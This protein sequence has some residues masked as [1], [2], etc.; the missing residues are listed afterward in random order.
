M[1]A[2]EEIKELSIRIFD[3]RQRMSEITN[4]PLPPVKLAAE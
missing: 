2:N 4:A 3:V 1:K